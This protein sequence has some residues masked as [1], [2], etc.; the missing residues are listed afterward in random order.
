[1]F[2]KLVYN[3]IHVRERSQPQSDARVHIFYIPIN[4]M[5]LLACCFKCAFIKSFIHAFINNRYLKS[6]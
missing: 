2:I 6:A 4:F 1:M 3:Y 5:M